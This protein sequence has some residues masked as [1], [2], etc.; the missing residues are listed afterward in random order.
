MNRDKE[1]H[2]RIVV[3]TISGRRRWRTRQISGT[4]GN[5]LYSYLQGIIGVRFAQDVVKWYQS[6]ADG[7]RLEFKDFY[8]FC[9]FA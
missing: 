9:Y 3:D 8:V 4:M 5:T 6:A 1:R 7:E 2:W